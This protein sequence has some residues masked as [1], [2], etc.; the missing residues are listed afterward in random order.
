MSYVQGNP[1][2]KLLPLYLSRH[3]RYRLVIANLVRSYYI[4]STNQQSWKSVPPFLST[5][6]MRV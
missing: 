1:F 5:Q 4:E 3:K 2:R 6:P